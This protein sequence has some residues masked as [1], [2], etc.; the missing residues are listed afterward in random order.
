MRI[1]LRQVFPLGRFHATPWRVN[2]FDDPFGEWPPSPWRL[3]RAIA[4][5]WYQWQREDGDRASEYIDSLLRALCTSDYGF[6]LP[7][8]AR[9]GFALRQYQPAEFSWH[10]GEKKKPGIRSYGTTLVQDNAWCVP[11]GQQDAGAVWWI[12]QGN[13]WTEDLLSVLDACLARMVYFGR[14]ETLTAIER[15]E[16]SVIEAN[17]RLKELPSSPRAAPVLVPQATATREDI[18][19]VTDDPKAKERTVP[20]GARRMYGEPP[21]SLP[22]WE[23][24]T[25]PSVHPPTHLIQFAVG[26][27]VAPEPRTVVRLT[28]RF[29]SQVITAFVR[30]KTKDPRS[31]WVTAPLSVREAAG[32]LSGKNGRG[33]PLTGHQHAMFL[34]WPQDGVLTRMLVW[35]AMRAF[36]DDEQNAILRAAERELSWTARGRK[37]SDEW[38]V[39]LVPLDRLVPPP[40]GFDEMRAGIWESVT[41]Y[42]PPRHHLRKGKERERE[43]VAEQVKRELEQCR[44]PGA[45]GVE[46]ETSGAATWVAVHV[47]A[48]KRRDRSV[49][50]DRRGYWLRI[51]FPEPVRGPI[52][53]GHSSHFGLG[54][55]QPVR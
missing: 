5:R 28:A 37:S 27:A 6:H 44:L 54:L 9:R 42:V 26:W 35:R 18:E 45:K 13:D 17:C 52:L 47:P 3:V 1:V 23:R 31:T 33:D 32:G 16:S 46:V 41:P 48:R 15:C 53:L 14:A 25:I 22:A 39:R 30:E 12:L 50:G 11:S 10:P 43:S 40:P 2:P 24:A 29:R 8:E 55:F 34:A 20:P 36:D 19:R 21:E 38:K 4:A 51:V 49:L 7:A